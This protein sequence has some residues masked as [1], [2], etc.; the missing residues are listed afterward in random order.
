MN[1]KRAVMMAVLAVAIAALA[2][3]IVG[4][5]ARAAGNATTPAVAA[6]PA[7]AVPSASAAT[8]EAR[9]GQR[10]MPIT[11]SV[12]SAGFGPLAPGQDRRWS[13]RGLRPT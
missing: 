12:D 1:L 6:K 4:L 11:T 9:T 7:A 13:F 8:Q 2:V 3:P 5:R 10:A